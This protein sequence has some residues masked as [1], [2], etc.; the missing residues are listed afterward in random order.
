MELM[1]VDRVTADSVGEPGHRT[2]YIQTR[3]DDELVTVLVEKEQVQLLAASILEILSRVDEET[4]EGPGE[5]EMALEEPIEPRW[6]AGRISLG[7]QQEADLV[8][9][10]ME[11]LL[12]EEP[13]EEGEAREA[14]QV[15]LWATREQMFSLSRHAA[16]VCARGRPTCGFCGNP[17]EPEGHVCPGMN[18]HKELGED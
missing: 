18:G 16:A 9:F 4:G 10:E 6:R 7:H 2:F 17:I 15:R 1:K 11:E 8:L 3:K 13:E 14:D 12:P 5:D